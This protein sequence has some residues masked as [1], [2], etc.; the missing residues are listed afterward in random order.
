MQQSIVQ[1]KQQD[2]HYNMHPSA[3]QAMGGV[4]GRMRLPSNL[5]GFSWHSVQ[6]ASPIVAM[7]N[8]E[9][10]PIAVLASTW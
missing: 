2:L 9:P 5:R 8:Y 7:I 10:V 3:Q 1:L 6:L 4:R